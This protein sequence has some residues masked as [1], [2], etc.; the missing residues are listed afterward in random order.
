MT[1]APKAKERIVP[2]MITRQG[3][4]FAPRTR[5]MRNAS[6][7]NATSP[8][9][10]CARSDNDPRAT[11]GAAAIRK[12]IESR[13]MVPAE[14]YPPLADIESYVEESHSDGSDSRRIDRLQLAL[15]KILKK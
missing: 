4:V 14:R 9:I 2:Q 11:S 13:C 8:S 7:M 12:L 1:I 6:T 5:P 10:A 3:I 15:E